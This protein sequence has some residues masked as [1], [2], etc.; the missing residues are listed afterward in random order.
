[1][2]QDTTSPQAASHPPP[3]PHAREFPI[4]AALPPPAASQRAASRDATGR[5]GPAE[6]PAHPASSEELKFHCHICNEPS[7]EICPHCTRDVCPNHICEH[8][9]LCS[10]CCACES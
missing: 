2:P 4:P 9:A 1:M 5:P 3:S 8:C 6:P 10:D 7:S